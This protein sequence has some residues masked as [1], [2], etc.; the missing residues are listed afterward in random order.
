MQAVQSTAWPFAL[1]ALPAA[2]AAVLRGPKVGGKF[3][4]FRGGKHAIG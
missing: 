2:F 4:H 1:L 3:N